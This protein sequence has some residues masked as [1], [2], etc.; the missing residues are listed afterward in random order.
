MDIKVVFL[1]SLEDSSL[2]GFFGC[3][4]HFGQNLFCAHLALGLNRI[5]IS[6]LSRKAGKL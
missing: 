5:V 1:N 6:N 2:G 4:S 3:K